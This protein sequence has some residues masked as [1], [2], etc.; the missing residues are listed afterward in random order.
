VAEAVVARGAAAGVL[1]VKNDTDGGGVFAADRAPIAGDPTVVERVA[2][3]DIRLG[4]A[5]FFQVH[6]AQAARLF[7]TVAAL[8][9]VG[10]GSR[11]LDLYC[12]VGPIAYTLA[13]AGATVLGIER[14]PEAI[15]RARAAAQSASLPGSVA[16]AVGD[17]AGAVA[18]VDQL[19]AGSAHALD[20]VVVNPPRKGLSAAARDALAQ[21]A[22]PRVI[23]VS[24][25]P[26]TLA[27]DVAALS[28]AG[29]ALDRAIPLDL[30]PGTAHIETIA[31]LKRA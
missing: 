21:L 1:W 14:A 29:Y 10:P 12:G 2:G 4:P 25:E 22:A 24:C 13:R 19:A 30:M 8:A 20:A 15:G 5:D 17:A 31:R 11:A 3:V 27:R 18:L 9:E 6:R 28:A 7:A 16:F 26:T 23:Y